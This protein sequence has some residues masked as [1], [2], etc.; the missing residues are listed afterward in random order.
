MKGKIYKEREK[1]QPNILNKLNTCRDNSTITSICTNNQRKKT[2]KT[3]DQKKS[4]ILNIYRHNQSKH[5]IKIMRSKLS[6]ILTKT[7]TIVKISCILCVFLLLKCTL[8]SD[9]T[10]L[11]FEPEC[12][13]IS[14][15]LADN[16]SLNIYLLFC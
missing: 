4:Y 8:S 16:F 9:G 12:F 3:I 1:T 5:I 7:N 13:L 11:N 10:R 14:R 6:K 2:Y 15:L